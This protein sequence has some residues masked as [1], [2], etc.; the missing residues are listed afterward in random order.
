MEEH[1]LTLLIPSLRDPSRT[2]QRIIFWAL[3][4][5][6]HAREEV[7]RFTDEA[8]GAHYVIDPTGMTQFRARLSKR[9]PTRKTEEQA[10]DSRSQSFHNKAPLITTLG[11]GYRASIGLI[12]AVMSLPHRILLVDEPEAFLHPTLARHVGRVL[13][14]TA[15]KRS[16]SLVAATHSSDFLYG[17]IQAEPNLRIIRLT[18]QEE[19]AT[20]RSIEPS[21]ILHMMSDPLLRS[22]NTLRA[23]FFKSVIVTEG[24]ADRAFYDE[25]NYR[26]QQSNSGI[27]DAVFLNAQNWQTIPRI[28]APLREI[29]VPAAAVFDFDVVMDKDF[30]CIWELFFGHPNLKELQQRRTHVKEVMEKRG[31]KECKRHGLNLFRN[32]ERQS[33]EEFISISAEF[34]IYFVP[35]G[36]LECWLSGLQVARHRDKPTWL[37]RMFSRLGSDPSSEEYVSPEEGDVWE[38][39][40]RIEVWMNDSNRR[41]LPN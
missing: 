19:K 39:I 24:D 37:T 35:V 18:F 26:L 36:E 3:F 10:L 30:K 34:G 14:E 29:G 5:D 16:A 33:I 21:R 28:V 2:L 1:A 25:I 12:S 17:C 27:E 8:F 7:R 6:D 9:K 31:R 13:A 15:R 23:M 11:D 40:K 32:D 41:G 22:A 38:F 4:K 20:A